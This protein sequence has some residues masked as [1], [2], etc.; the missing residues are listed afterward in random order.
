MIS[1]LK[2]ICQDGSCL[3]YFKTKRIDWVNTYLYTSGREGDDLTK[4][5]DILLPTVDLLVYKSGCQAES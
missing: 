3:F 1:V 2:F 4:R 5:M